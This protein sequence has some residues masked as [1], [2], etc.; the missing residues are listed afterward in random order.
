[1][2]EVSIQHCEAMRLGV[3]RHVGPY[4]GIGEAFTRLF[5]WA[6]G[7]GLV[8]P[9]RAVGVYW[10]NPKTTP[11]SELRSAAGVEVSADFAGDPANGIEIQEVEGSDYAVAVY[12]GSYEGLPG[13]Y[14]WLFA[15][16][17][18][19]SGRELAD[20]PCCEVYLNNPMDT[21]PE[22]LLTE[23]RLPLA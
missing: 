6:F 8:K 15:H 13:A 16:W 22:D 7:G 1:M 12:R 2:L 11:E 4:P 10:D 3:I 18:A 21:A 9:G 17:C 5:A 20:K 19:E 23:I 14:D